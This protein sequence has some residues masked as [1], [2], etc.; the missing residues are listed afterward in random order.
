MIPAL[1][2]IVDN[3]TGD[4]DWRFV[5]PLFA[6]LNPGMSASRAKELDDLGFTMPEIQA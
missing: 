1:K 2:R 4:E 6:E 5:R 3:Y